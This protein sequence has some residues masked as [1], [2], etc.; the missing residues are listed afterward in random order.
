M[1]YSVSHNILMEDDRKTYNNCILALRKKAVDT[2]NNKRGHGP[3]RRVA[4]NLRPKSPEENAEIQQDV[5]YLPKEL[6]E[7]FRS[8]QK[9]CTGIIL[10][11]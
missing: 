7:S 4:S 3:L 6:M 11:R 9:K 1:S 10:V 8:K 5:R 2:E